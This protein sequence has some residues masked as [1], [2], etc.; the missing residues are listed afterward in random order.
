LPKVK[1]KLAAILAADVAG[2]SRLMAADET[3]TLVRIKK[4]RAEVIEPRIARRNGR[5]VGSA[6]DSLLVQSVYDQ[7]KT[8][9]ACGFADLGEQRMHNIPGLVRVYRIIPRADP[10]R[11]RK[12]RP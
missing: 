1:R 7:V 8:K 9:L 4:W 6:G 3:G 5:I 10:S 2:Y 11:G 12:S